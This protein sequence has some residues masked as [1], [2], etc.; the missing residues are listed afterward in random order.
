MYTCTCTP[1]IFL[2]LYLF[3]Y[4]CVYLVSCVY[5]LCKNEPVVFHSPQTFIASCL[6]PSLTGIQLRHIS[7]LHFQNKVH[8]SLSPAVSH[9]SKWPLC[10]LCF[11]P[12]PSVGIEFSLVCSTFKLS[13]N[14]D[15]SPLTC[16][17]SHSSPFPSSHVHL[18]QVSNSAFLSSGFHSAAR[19]RLI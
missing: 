13:G 5:V 12:D 19:I 16:M 2:H 17:Y 6:H 8:F 4:L 14:F 3:P 9:I 7:H 11:S 18:P 1:D 15:C 10:P